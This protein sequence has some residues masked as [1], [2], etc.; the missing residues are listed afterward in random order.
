MFAPSKQAS[1]TF[2]PLFGIFSNTSS[3]IC[4]ISYQIVLLNKSR[5]LCHYICINFFAEYLLDA[6]LC[7]SDDV[8]SIACRSVSLHCCIDCLDCKLYAIRYFYV[9]LVKG[10]KNTVS[11]HETA[12]ICDI[13]FMLNHASIDAN[14]I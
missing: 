10:V 14:V 3:N 5:N 11:H 9:W 7:Y 6:L 1:L 4:V 8:D 12:A 2:L 13:V